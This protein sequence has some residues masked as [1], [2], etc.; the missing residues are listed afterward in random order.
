MFGFR[1]PVLVSDILHYALTPPRM[2][3]RELSQYC[4]SI[5]IMRP[6]ARSWYL[7]SS[8]LSASNTHLSG[9]LFQPINLQD[10]P[11]VFSGCKHGLHSVIFEI[12]RLTCLNDLH[13]GRTALR[14]LN[15]RLIVHPQGFI[16]WRWQQAR[17]LSR[18]MV[19]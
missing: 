19:G 16:L 18:F 8:E 11:A 7:Q 10:I 9:Q 2:Y 14:Q 3:T 5:P 1:V 6:E 12:H 13:E 17:D 15:N 4:L